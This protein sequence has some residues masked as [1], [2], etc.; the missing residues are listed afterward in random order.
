MAGQADAGQLQAGEP[1]RFQDGD[2]ES[3]RHSAALLEHLS[4]RGVRGIVVG[5]GVSPEFLFREEDAPQRLGRGRF[6]PP[7]LPHA[8][9]E[10]LDALPRAGDVL[11]RFHELRHEES[12]LEEVRLRPASE[13]PEALDDGLPAGHAVIHACARSR[14]R[15]AEER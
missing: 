7:R 10:R 14:H 2:R 6:V 13:T 12:P 3:D 9:R 1:P 4:D 8:R 5:V 11:A 15:R